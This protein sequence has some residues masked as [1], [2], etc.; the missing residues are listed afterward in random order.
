MW[1]AGALR[2]APEST[3]RTRRRARARTRA[4]DKPAAPPPITAT[5]Y[6]VDSMRTRLARARAP[7]QLVLPFPGKRS[8]VRQVEP[9]AVVELGEESAA[10]HAVTSAIA[11]ALGQVGA[12]LKRVRMQR[13]MTLTGVAAST[14][15]SKST[16]SR[17]ETG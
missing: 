9:P 6:C 12:R 1:V 17:L 15:I 7:R 3:T 4:A 8:L 11:A 14:G 5:S 10:P 16:L 2:G 13:R